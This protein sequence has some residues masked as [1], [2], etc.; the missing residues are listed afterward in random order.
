MICILA[1]FNPYSIKDSLSKSQEIPNIN[2]SATS[3]NNLVK[4]LIASEHVVYVI[5]LDFSSSKTRLFNG[6][7][8]TVVAIGCRSK[9]FLKNLFPNIENIANLIAAEVGKVKDKISI[10]HAH[11]CYEYAL[12][13]MKYS[14]DIATLVTVRDF[15][16][17][18]YSSINPFASLYSFFAKF[19]WYYKMK[20]FSKVLSSKNIFFVSNSGYTERK[21]KE[22]NLKLNVRT[23]P[24]SIEDSLLVTRIP[25][26]AGRKNIVS[27]AASLDDNRKNIQTLIDAFILFS[28]K[29][30]GYKLVLIGNYHK[31]S[32]VYEYSKKR[33][34]LGDVIFKGSLNRSDIIE[35]IDN[36]I[37]MVHPAFEE[38]FGNILLESMARGV[39]AIG[40]RSAGAVP[41]VLE[42]GNS[43]IL[44][45]I[46]SALQICNAMESVICEAGSNTFLQ[47]NALSWVG[48][49][50]T[51]SAVAKQHILLYKNLLNK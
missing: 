25:N 36:S 9:F 1:P 2:P 34:L 50:F 31:N 28:K 37:M 14:S 49:N 26:T 6:K 40:G 27:I 15:A 33:G 8:I 17:V 4:G 21:L 20:I 23:I 5:T 22:Y 42:K 19:Y 12:A 30:S 32:G 13:A 7:N 11:W 48:C 45:D 10:L 16:P 24:N 47:K 39:I 51:N 38:T 35:I 46:S 3:I 29:Y 43:G 44:C 18:I 41:Y